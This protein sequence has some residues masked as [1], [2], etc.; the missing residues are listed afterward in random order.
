MPG[1]TRPEPAGSPK[2]REAGR[3]RAVSQRRWNLGVWIVFQVERRQ[4][5][6]LAEDSVGAKFRCERGHRA[7]VPSGTAGR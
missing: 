5:A 6:Y 4:K 3:Q 7:T 2:D 1:D